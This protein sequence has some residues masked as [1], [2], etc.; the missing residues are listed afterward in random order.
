MS[1]DMYRFVNSIFDSNNQNIIYI[2]IKL[3]IQRIYIIFNSI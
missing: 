3:N 2:Y 1:N